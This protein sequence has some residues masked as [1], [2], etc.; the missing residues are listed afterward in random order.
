MLYRATIG[1]DASLKHISCPIIFLSPANDFH[2]RI[3]DLPKAAQEISSSEWR[4]TCSAHHNHQDTEPYQVAGSLWFDQHLKGA[5]TFPRT[6][7]T[8]LELR[9]EDGVPGFTVTPDVSQEILSVDIYYTQQGQSGEAQEPMANAIHRF[10]HH[11]DAQREGNTWTADL[12][13]L[14]TDAP[15]WAYANVLYPVE[16]PVS[17]AGYYYAPYTARTLNLSS[18]MHAATPAELEAAGVRATASPSLV[19]ET[20]EDKWEKEWFTYDLSDNWARRTHKIY[21]DKWQPPPFAKL[22]FDVRSE[23]PNKMVVGV[24]EFGA[25]VQLEG[26]PQWQHVLLYQTDFRDAVGRSFV[27][28]GDAKELRLGPAETLRSGQGDETKTLHLGADWQGPDPQ[29]RDLRWVEGTREELNARRTVKL[30]TGDGGR[31]YLKDEYADA[32]S[33]LV[34]AH[35]DADMHGEPLTVDGKTY[36]HGMT[37]HAPSEATF[38]LGGKFTRFHVIAAAGPNSTVVFRVAIDGQTV[39]D[40]GLLARSAFRAIDL[41]VAGAQEAQLIVADGGNGQGGDWAHWVDAWLARA[42]E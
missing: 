40:S 42:P 18:V 22:A 27:G 37:V 28:W 24:G 31:T 20:F 41:P 32:F 39:Y 38:F 13:L 15:L 10:W 11:A 35:M 4:L 5:F 14:S 8:A 3:D 36:D 26:G 29:L 1:D 7:Q 25:E 6:P 19:I 16:E 33:S 30:P 34:P 2:G 12:P 17:G 23:Q 9:T 21:D